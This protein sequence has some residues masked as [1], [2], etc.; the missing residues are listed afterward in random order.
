MKIP[1]TGNMNVRLRMY[2][3]LLFKFRRHLCKGSISTLK[4][5]AKRPILKTGN[6][7]AFLGEICGEFQCNKQVP[8]KF[9]KAP[10]HVSDN[11][12]L[13]IAKLLVLGYSSLPLISI[14]LLWSR[15]TYAREIENTTI[16]GHL[17]FVIEENS[18]RKITWL[19]TVT[20]W[21]S[22]NS[23]FKRFSVHILKR[24][25]GDFKFFCF[26]YGSYKVGVTVGKKSAL[27]NIFRRRVDRI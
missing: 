13:A 22:K 23:V 12:L 11:I 14:H 24:K 15:P 21:C 16:T 20:S 27:W 18:V 26:L 2:Q 7:G 8:V 9:S 10:E 25:A 3:G 4:I 1:L 5:L 6:H 17:G 19:S